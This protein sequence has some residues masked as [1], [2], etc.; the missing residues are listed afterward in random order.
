MQ[1]IKI[2]KNVFTEFNLKLWVR[3]YDI[4]MTSATSGFI[5]FIPNTITVSSLKKSKLSTLDSIFQE[6]F[7]DH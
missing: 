6:M 4:I 5:E 3:T 7:G 2:V 1:L